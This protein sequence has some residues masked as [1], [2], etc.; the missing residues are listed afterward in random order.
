MKTTIF[1]INAT[2]FLAGVRSHPARQPFRA[3]SLL[4]DASQQ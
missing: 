2:G 3:A 4:P 1:R